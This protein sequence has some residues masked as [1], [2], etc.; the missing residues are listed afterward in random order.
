MRAPSV[1]LT[2][3]AGSDPESAVGQNPGG[4]EFSPELAKVSSLA[5]LTRHLSAAALPNRNRN[6]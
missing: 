5:N 3:P 2:F 1:G 4:S 6:S